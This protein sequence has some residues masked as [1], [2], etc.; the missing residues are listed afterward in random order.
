MDRQPTL[1]FTQGQRVMAHADTLR[2]QNARAVCVAL[3]ED[4]YCVN[5][6]FV[7]LADANFVVDIAKLALAQ[8]NGIQSL[9]AWI[10]GA[11]IS[12]QSM[13]K[14]DGITEVIFDSQYP[15][16]AFIC[17]A[18]RRPVLTAEYVH[19]RRSNGLS[20]IRAYGVEFKP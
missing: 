3:S 10:E 6:P 15:E 12:P 20:F 19:F 17:V 7:W 4:H 13:H 1:E 5:L 2:G 9:F 18:T 11:I 16:N 14:D 8:A